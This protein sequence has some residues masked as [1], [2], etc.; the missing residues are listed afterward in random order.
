MQKVI[1]T[2]GA[3]GI[4]RATAL[5]FLANGAK[6][7]V[8]DIDE[9]ALAK[10]EAE[11]PDIHCVKAD[12]SDEKQNRQ[13]MAE[14]LSFLGGIDVLVNNAGTS[15]PTGNVEDL[16]LE[17]F[18]A[19]LDVNVLGGFM[20]TLEAV[21]VMKAQR[22]GVI[23]NL[24]SAAGI[25]PFPQRIP[26]SAAKWGIV[27]MTKSLALELG[28]S[29]IRVNCICPGAVNGDRIQRVFA[30]KA[31]ATGQTREAVQ[32]QITNLTGMK[33]MVENEDIA[34]A[35]YFLASPA[36]RYIS[37]QALPVDGAIISLI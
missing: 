30:A 24:S 3:S 5:K 28:A 11:A 23:I 13:F 20:A 7:A 17:D 19:C 37:G 29:G 4:G 16:S 1:I 12:V 36:A 31:K 35:V 25:Y 26:Y 21:P 14:A 15:G 22:S 18:K 10:F 2:A 32:E 34:E 9:T 33:T 27:G 6:I 8:C